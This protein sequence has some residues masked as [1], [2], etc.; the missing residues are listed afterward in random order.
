MM[1]VCLSVS[2]S[3]VAHT[4]GLQ[5]NYQTDQHEHLGQCWDLDSRLA[6]AVLWRPNPRLQMAANVKIV[7]LAYISI[8]CEFLYDD[9]KSETN[10]DQMW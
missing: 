7:L 5:E 8:F 10:D 2:L 1:S 3:S 6:A 9:S 4:W